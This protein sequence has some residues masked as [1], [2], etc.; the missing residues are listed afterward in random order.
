MKMPVHNEYSIQIIADVC[1]NVIYGLLS[2]AL[3]TFQLQTL[4]DIQVCLILI[5]KTDWHLET[6]DL[7]MISTTMI[8]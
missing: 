1:R 3:N 4:G 6:F 2:A 8:H 7:D 5:P